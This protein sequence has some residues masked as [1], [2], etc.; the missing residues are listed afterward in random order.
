LRKYQELPES[1]ELVQKQRAYEREIGILRVPSKRSFDVEAQVIDLSHLEC[2]LMD[3]RL[4]QTDCAE[5]HSIGKILRQSNALIL[6]IDYPLGLS[7]YDILAEVSSNVGQILGIYLMGKAAT[8]NAVIGDVMIS[9]VVHDEQSQNTYLFPNCFS[10][11]NIAP[12]LI[13]GTVLDNQKIISVQGTFLQNARYMD[14]FYREG[15]TVIEME[16]GP[17]LSAI[18]EMVRPK[19]HPVN[20]IVNLYGLPFDLGVVN[21]ASDTPLGKGKNLGAGSLSYSGMDST[22]AVTLAIIRR[23]FALEEKRINP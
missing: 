12:E 9:N 4:R 3:S 22:Y 16:S 11:A 8:L 23:I 14:V 17:Y 13:H 15:Y 18:Y 7:A 20:E 10:A 19:R 6:N 5:E 2:N 21:Y 1:R